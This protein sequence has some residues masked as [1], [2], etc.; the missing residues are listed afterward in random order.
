VKYNGWMPRPELTRFRVQRDGNA[1]AVYVRYARGTRPEFKWS[2]HRRGF[3]TWLEAIV[4]ANQLAT[5]YAVRSRA[6]WGNQ[7]PIQ[8]MASL[9]EAS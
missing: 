2:W 7:P 3:T 9:L 6:E 5:E 8:T 1:W 4:C